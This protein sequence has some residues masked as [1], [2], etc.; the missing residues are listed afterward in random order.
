MVA[1]LKLEEIDRRG[2]RAGALVMHLGWLGRALAQVAV[3]EEKNI[4]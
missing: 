3:G 1:R 2:T 4:E